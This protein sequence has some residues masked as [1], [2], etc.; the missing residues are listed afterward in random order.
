M[1]LTSPQGQ[2]SHDY[3]RVLLIEFWL[4]AIVQGMSFLITLKWITL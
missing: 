4:L 2:T 3:L 1:G